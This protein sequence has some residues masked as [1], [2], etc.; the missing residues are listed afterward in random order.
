MA[1]HSSI[2][3]WEIPETEESARLLQSMQ[4]Q[5]GQIQL[6][7][8]ATTNNNG[9]SSQYVRTQKL[10]GIGDGAETKVLL[11][12][13]VDVYLEKPKSAAGEY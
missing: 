10:Q 8:S 6:S 9:S 3:A 4:S 1:T 12:T 5:K 2:L 11:F 7:N 13:D